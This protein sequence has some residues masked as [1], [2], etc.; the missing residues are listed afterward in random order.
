MRLSVCADS[1]AAI[2]PMEL[3]PL[4]ERPLVSVLIA[5]FNY[6]KYIGAA[7]EGVFAQDYQNFEICIC[8]DG[9]T[10]DSAEVIRRYAERD[11]RVKFVAQQNGGQSSALST[12]WALAQGDVIAL[13]DSDDVWTP[14]K[15]SRVLTIFWSPAMPGLVAHRLTPV[16]A[17]LKTIRPRTQPAPMDSGWLAPKLLEPPAWITLSPCSGM[18][19]RSEIAQRVFPLGSAFRVFADQ[20]IGDRAS[21]V[22][23]IVSTPEELGCIRIHGANIA[24]CSGPREL[25]AIRSLIAHYEARMVDRREFL[26]REHGVDLRMESSV[27][28]AD[29]R[30]AEL[31]LQGRRP[32]PELLSQVSDLS[33]ARLWR[34]LFA[35]PTWLGV[36]LF[37]MRGANS[38]LKIWLKSL[39][40]LS[41]G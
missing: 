13:L 23:R 21:F 36:R 16:W 31:L 28:G 25:A 24:S 12:A 14:M 29:A 35:C 2:R 40:G 17:N 22:T 10:D 32:S 9:S 39:L 26:L 41:I 11:R 33:K 3:H 6:A 18:T 4:R 19:L 34:V 20:A 5:N 1:V 37:R 30:L 7:I 38:P 8:D 15:L 27:I